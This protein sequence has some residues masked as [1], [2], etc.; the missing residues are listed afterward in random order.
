MNT[1]NR[2][3]GVFLTVLT[4]A[5]A[6]GAPRAF[7]QDGEG[8]R[9]TG[10]QG[11]VALADLL[12]DT[13]ARVSK[14]I[15]RSVKTRSGEDVGEVDDLIA[16]P[17]RDAT[18]VVVLSVG[19]VLGVGEKQYATSFDKLSMRGDGDELVLDAT[20]DE[21]A[22]TPA[23]D[24]RARMGERSVQPGVVGP[25]T[26]NSIGQLLG[27]TLVDESG[28]TLGEVEDLV[29]STG[30]AGTRAIVVPEGGT[31]ER[32]VAIPFDE[33]SIDR[34]GEEAAG[35]IQQPEVRVALDETV[36]AGLPSYEYPEGFPN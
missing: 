12:N 26:A 10:A 15:G 18:P 22:E 29:V 30:A 16:M 4:L 8:A 24:Y 19:G 31:D 3:H 17:G 5:A 11:G 1:T 28:E 27:A 35:I 7:G 13:D 23:F 20:R 33:L 36:I 25:T 2:Y 14:L 6:L 34:S 21:V 32:R 9:A